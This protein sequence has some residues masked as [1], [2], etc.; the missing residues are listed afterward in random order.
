M[1]DLLAQL[2]ATAIPRPITELPLA[3]VADMEPADQLQ[4]I[5]GLLEAWP[6]ETPVPTPDNA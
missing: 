6:D 1:P 3:A 5:A 4:V 2:H